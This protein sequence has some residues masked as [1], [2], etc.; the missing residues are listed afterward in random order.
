MGIAGLAGTVTL[1]MS[2]T[3]CIKGIKMQKVMIAKYRGRCAV[4]GAAIS[5]GDEITYCTS[6]KKAWLHEPGDCRVDTGAYLGNKKRVSDVFN[7]GGSEYYR[8]KSG[9]CIDAPC[10]GCCTI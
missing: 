9:R 10:C 6:S 8:N 3:T 2:H 4:S 7:I 1:K 5:P